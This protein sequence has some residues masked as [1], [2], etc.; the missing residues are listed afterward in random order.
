MQRATTT[1]RSRAMKRTRNGILIPD[2]PIMAGGNL[3]NAVKGVSAGG[4]DKPLDPL[5]VRCPFFIKNESADVALI[6]IFKRGGNSPSIEIDISQNA[7]DWETIGTTSTDG[8]YIN[9]LPYSKLYLRA[10]I[11]SWASSSALISTNTIKV[12][13]NYSIGGNLLSL[14]YGEEFNGQKEFKNESANAFVGLFYQEDNQ[15]AYLIDASSLQLNAEIVPMGAYDSMFHFCYN[16]EFAPII[17]GQIFGDGSCSV[18][19]DGCSKINR[20]EC[21]ATNPTSQQFNNWVQNV[22]PNGTF[23]KKRGVTWPS[24]NS[25]IPTGWTV[26]EID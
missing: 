26:E 21:H 4:N 17:K 6:R 15:E 23:V 22:A 24:G 10:E 9:I 3:P 7:K 19:F 5:D 14:L 12:N 20:I 2:V 8:L 16:L 13:K 11:S 25:G 1:E 18:L